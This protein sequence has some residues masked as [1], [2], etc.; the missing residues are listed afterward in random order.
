[1][2]QVNPTL[3][4]APAFFETDA[5][6]DLPVAYVETDTYGMITRANRASMELLPTGQG[7]LIGKLAWDLM[8]TDEKEQNC[9]AYTM[10]MMTG[11]DPPIVRRSIITCS[12]EFRTFKMYRRLMHN[13]AGEIV[14]MRTVSVD[15]TRSQHEL[16]EANRKL[17]WNTSILA[18]LPEA[19]LVTDA[20]G[21]I[22]DVNPA[23]E[24]L[25]GWKAKE[26]VGQPIEKGV[27]LVEYSAPD[28]SKLDLWSS[29]ERPTDGIATTLDRE[30]R[31][32]RIELKTLPMV[33]QSNGNT[34]G[35]AGIMRRV[36]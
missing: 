22:S 24:A 15:V 21:F 8:P 10:L 18:A 20:L 1:M 23:A 33:D 25:L 27:P 4:A 12:G 29:L 13:A 14:G 16:E 35:V 11:E 32:L 7:D 31:E 5:I 6:D 28:G 3:A 9:A 19:V 36:E 26:L 34:I 2:N 17:Q 30:G